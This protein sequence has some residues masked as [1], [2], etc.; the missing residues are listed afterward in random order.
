MTRSRQTGRQRRWSQSRFVRAEGYLALLFLI[1]TVYNPALAMLAIH[2]EQYSMPLRVIIWAIAW[3]FGL[4]GARHGSGA[5]RVCAWVTLIV[6][7][8]MAI[9]SLLWEYVIPHQGLT[10]STEMQRAK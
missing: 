8:C 6:L 9:F 10:W 7:T 4:S 3:L 5:A 1:L 2:H